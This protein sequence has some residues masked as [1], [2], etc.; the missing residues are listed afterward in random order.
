MIMVMHYTKFNI[1]KYI[2]GFVVLDKEKFR[3]LYNKRNTSAQRNKS[4]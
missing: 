1:K 2:L 4:R 3:V